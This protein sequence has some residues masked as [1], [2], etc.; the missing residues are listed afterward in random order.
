MEIDVKKI[1]RINFKYRVIYLIKA[2][3]YEKRCPLAT[4]VLYRLEEELKEDEGNGDQG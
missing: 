1:D 4:D 2:L 3:N